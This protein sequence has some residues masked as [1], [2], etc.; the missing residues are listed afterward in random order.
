MRHPTRWNRRSEHNA[1]GIGPVVLQAFPDAGRAFR[2]VG[3]RGAF[4][5]HLKVSVGAVAEKF[6]TAR[7][8]IGEAGHVLFG[9]RI[10]CPMEMDGGHASLSI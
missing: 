9:R 2:D 1:T 10:G 6:R 8:E 4:V 3:L 7:P 5:M